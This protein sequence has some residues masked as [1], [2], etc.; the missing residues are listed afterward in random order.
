M[1]HLL[2]A[3]NHDLI[4]FNIF[5]VLLF[6]VNTLWHRDLAPAATQNYNLMLASGDKGTVGVLTKLLRY[7]LRNLLKGINAQKKV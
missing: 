5:I 7:L 1:N 2:M 4:L 6:N 3:L